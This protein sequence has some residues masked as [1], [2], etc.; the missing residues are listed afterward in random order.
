VSA[1]PAPVA[2]REPVAVAPPAPLAEVD[3]ST[4]TAPLAAPEFAAL[5]VPL[6]PFGS[7]PRLVAGVSGGPHSLALALLLAR[8]CAARG[9]TLLAGIVDH[10]LRAESAAE[11]ATVAGWMAARGIACQVLALGLAPGPGA[12]ARAREARLAALLGLAAAAGAPWLALGQHRGDQAETLLL[13]ALAG[14]GPAGLAGMAL[15]RS[16]GAALLIRPLLGLAPARL[17]ATVAAAGM[18]P[19]RDPSNADPRFTRARLRAALADPAGE[20]A[21]TRA[22]AAAADVFACRRAAD[23]A[24]V[25]RRLALAARLRPEGFARLDLATLGRDAV[26]V[27]GLAALVRAVGGGAFAPSAA[28]VAALLARGEGTLGGARLTRHGL[29]LREVAALSP[30]VPAR[31]GACWDGRFVLEGEPPPGCE[32]AALGADATRLPRPAWLPAEAARALA[33]VRRDTVLVAV[34]ALSYR[35][36]GLPCQVRLRFAPRGG[37]VA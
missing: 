28:A 1:P 15:A 17:E 3:V 29:L 4:L 20:G 10:G 19:L 36:T 2:E 14:S 37:A 24:A 11:A 13:R 35:V 23:R 33:S 34:P 26:A 18:V 27:A 6:G 22:L 7:R 21:A 8:W 30:P 25:A 5:M 9:G 32:I 12:Q 16:A 31:P